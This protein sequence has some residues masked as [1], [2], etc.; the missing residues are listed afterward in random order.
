M[1][2]QVLGQPLIRL[3]G[4]SASQQPVQPRS[5]APLGHPQPVRAQLLGVA[6][7]AQGQSGLQQ[8]LDGAREPHRAARRRLQHL[9]AAP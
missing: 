5:Q 6:P 4:E 9:P 3:V 7:I 1:V 2:D 8:S